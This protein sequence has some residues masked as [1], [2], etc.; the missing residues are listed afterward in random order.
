[1]PPV[2]RVD[3]QPYRAR[4]CEGPEHRH[5]R[6]RSRAEYRA[7]DRT[8]VALVSGAVCLHW[9]TLERRSKRPCS[10]SGRH[11]SLNRMTDVPASMQRE[12]TASRSGSTSSL[13]I[14]ELRTI[15][16]AVS[17]TAGRLS[18]RARIRF[19]VDFAT[20][21]VECYWNETQRGASHIW[22]VHDRFDGFDV[23]P[24]EHGSR[25]LAMSLGRVAARADPVT[26]GYFIGTTYAAAIPSELRSRLGVYYT[27]PAVAARLLDQVA[28]AGVDWRSCTVLDPACGGGAFLA[29]AA[30]RIVKELSHWEP[31][32]LLDALGQR[33]RGF[34]IDPVAAWMSQVFLEAMVMPVCQAARRRLPIVVE[35]RNTLIHEPAHAAFDLVV[36]NPPYG[37][38]T[39]APRIRAR[40]QRSLYGHANL[41]GL[42]TDLAFRWVKAGGVVAYVTPT[43]FLA[44]EYFKNLRGMLGFEGTPLSIDFIGD[45]RGVFDEVLQE[46]L[47]ATYRRSTSGGTTRTARSASV[48]FVTPIDETIVGIS[49]VGSFELPDDP[50]APWLVPRDTSQDALIKQLRSMPHRLAD[51]GY[52]VSTGPLVWNRHKD[53]LREHGA[54]GCLPL[55]WAE[56]VR[57]DGRFQMQ[58]TKTNHRA[59]FKVRPYDHWLVIDKPCVLVQRTT[60]K[61]QPRRL[62]AAVLP[63]AFIREHGGV[64]VENH[65]NMIR[66]IGRPAVGLTTL[67][68]FMNSAVAD[69]IF[70]CLSGSV[71][72][73]AY[74]LEALP[75]P[76][77]ECLRDFDASVRRGES[78]NALDRIAARLYGLDGAA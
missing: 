6:T 72:V 55:V 18:R 62:V 4:Q 20:A 41:Y 26:A 2:S 71:A 38:I 46:T 24:L 56:A 12:Q 22:P 3:D 49:H 52:E 33:I 54:P 19:A 32:P 35:V 69:A 59:Y 45:R 42:F 43:S 11:A 40:Y 23:R 66:P 70:R 50:H 58:V 37:R 73:S 8:V 60:A 5:H 76:A 63:A 57:P 27:P 13:L 30:E 10:W 51:W 67:A 36:G 17:L 21:A 16:Q 61:E 9:E 64:V 44:G 7:R 14:D 25:S 78:R 74:E 65:L 1:M 31:G 75:L 39:L 48:A 28:A 15:K 29:P 47:L 68:A 34:E 53:Q 77:P